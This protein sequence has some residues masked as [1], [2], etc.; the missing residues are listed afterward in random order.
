MRDERKRAEVL[1]YAYISGYSAYPETEAAAPRGRLR[2][3]HRVGTGSTNRSRAPICSPST[4]MT[5]L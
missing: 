5:K 4:I 2:N 3:F 1:E